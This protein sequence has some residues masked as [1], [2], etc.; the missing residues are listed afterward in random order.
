M[1]K[2]FAAT[3]HPDD[4]SNDEGMLYYPVDVVDARI[5]E[6]E[7]YERAVKEHN[8]QCQQR[9]GV[10]DQEAVQCRYR[11]YFVSNGRRCPN[12]PVHE[13]IDIEL[14]VRSS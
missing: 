4:G 6:L 12:C 13:K 5:A 1:K 8:E 10:G 14:M 9:C 2:Y 3:V 11:P 7:K